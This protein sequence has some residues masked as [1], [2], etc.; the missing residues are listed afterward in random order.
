MSEVSVAPAPTTSAPSSGASESSFSSSTAS[1]SSA[2]PAAETKESAPRTSRESSRDLLRR[3]ARE[4]L[5]KA[6]PESATEGESSESEEEVTESASAPKDTEAEGKKVEAKPKAEPESEDRLKIRETLKAIPDK[7]TR[8][9]IADLAF[10]GKELRD[11]G[12]KPADARAYRDLYPTLDSAKQAH[13]VST[14]A[15]DL[16]GAFHSNSPEGHA[17][18]LQALQAANPNAYTNFITK[19]ARD[20]PTVN[21]QAY[22]EVG[23]RTAR[24][25]IANMRRAAESFAQRGDEVR[26][27]DLATA[28]QLQEEFLFPNGLQQQNVQR[29][30]NDPVLQEN[31]RLKAEFERAQQ[32]RIQGARQYAFGQY[33]HALTAEAAKVVNEIDADNV[34]GEKARQRMVNEV[35][36]NVRNII[37]NNNHVRVSVD[38]LLMRGDGNGAAR[39]LISQ[40][41]GLIPEQVANVVKDY[42][43]LYE[44][45]QAVRE[46]KRAVVTAKKDVGAPASAPRAASNRPVDTRGMSSREALKTLVSRRLSPR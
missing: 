34:Y 35:V 30:A 8:E 6:S 42:A 15:Y 38:T 28:A 20:L 17:H 5:E 40:A 32:E 23:Q 14:E 22:R 31:A 25:V 26:A 39:H 29:P 44:R 3:Q 41:T 43:D 21:P 46:E 18:F 11:A 45:K 24:N 19:V 1:E 9:Q 10:M 33:Q 13:A 37:G 7:K 4:A 27:H 2:A 36:Q 12:I 16:A